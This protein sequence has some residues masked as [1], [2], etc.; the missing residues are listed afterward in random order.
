MH[1]R[2]ALIT[3]GSRGI[4][5]AIALE[6]AR[7]GAD[8]AITYRRD[9]AAARET[10][11]QIERAGGRSVAVQADVSQ[12]TDNERSV[13]EAR[14]ALGTIDLL[15]C[16]AGIASRGRSVEHSELDEFERVMGVHVL[17]AVQLCKLLLDDLRAGPRGDVILIGSVLTQLLPPN[18]APY[19]MAK[20]AEEA[21]AM[22]LAKEERANGIHVNVVAP[23]LVA[24]DMG[25]RLAVATMGATEQ[26][27]DLDAVSPFGR[28]CRPEDVANAVRFLA[29]EDAGYITGHRLA[30]DGG[31]A[32][33]GG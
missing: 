27:A 29:S 2:T 5:R 25:D 14:A 4:G 26:A 6:L 10:V 13:A 21:F 19:A 23:G 9:E 1:D 24:T 11:A 12:R 31:G 15:V 33:Q 7:A 18:S 17:G 8:V 30:V 3:G 20:A 32:W 22:M 16:N 28:V